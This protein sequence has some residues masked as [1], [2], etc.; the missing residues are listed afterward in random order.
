MNKKILCVYGGPEFHATQK[1]GEL[2]SQ[3]LTQHGGYELVAT[4]DLDMLTRLN[5]DA[6]RSRVRISGY[7]H[8]LSQN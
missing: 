8:I 3:W 4:N 1:G 5:S 7:L 6:R 2:L